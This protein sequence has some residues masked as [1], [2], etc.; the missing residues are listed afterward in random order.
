[1]SAPATETVGGLVLSRRQS[2]ERFLLLALLSPE[3]GVLNF[4]LRDSARPDAARPDLFDLAEVTLTAPR[5]AGPRFGSNYR[6]LRRLDALGADIARLD[7]AC[8]L[9][10]VIAGNPIPDESAPALFA[11]FGRALEAIASRPRPDAAYIKA[12]WQI[13]RGEG[14]PVREQWLASLPPVDAAALRATLRQPLD[15]VAAPPAE[16]GQLTLRLERWLAG[17]CHFSIPART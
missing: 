8:R 13:V 6:I 1:M 3:K 14:F 17:E 12:L 10:R 15:A 5:N 4:L 16:V 7:A 11:L 2:G 9:A